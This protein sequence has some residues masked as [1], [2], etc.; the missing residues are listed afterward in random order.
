MAVRG[1]SAWPTNIN[2][3]DEDDELP[4]DHRSG[5]TDNEHSVAWMGSKN[6]GEKIMRCSAEQ[7][8][9]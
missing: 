1:M 5:V 2:E 6:S 4:V 8:R 7:V 3:D 9:V